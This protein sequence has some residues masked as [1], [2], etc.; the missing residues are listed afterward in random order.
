MLFRSTD[1]EAYKKI[2]EAESLKKGKRKATTAPPR[3]TTAP[4]ASPKRPDHSHLFCAQLG[5]EI[6]EISSSEDDT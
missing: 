1:P 5:E 6:I 3:K 4:M 2:E